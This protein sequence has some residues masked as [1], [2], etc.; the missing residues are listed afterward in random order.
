MH[1]TVIDTHWTVLL[2]TSLIYT[3]T[4]AH[5]LYR[6]TH[7]LISPT[8]FRVIALYQNCKYQKRSVLVTLRAIIRCTLYMEFDYPVAFDIDTGLTYLLFT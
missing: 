2:V 5:Y 3:P 7:W 1:A 4:R 8:M 6:S